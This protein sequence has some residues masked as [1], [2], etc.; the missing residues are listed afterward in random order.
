VPKKILKCEFLWRRLENT[1]L[2]PTR[3]LV[4]IFFQDLFSRWWRGLTFNCKWPPEAEELSAREVWKWA[5]EKGVDHPRCSFGFH[6]PWKGGTVSIL[7]Q[8]W[9]VAHANTLNGEGV[10]LQVKRLM[11]D[12]LSI[13]ERYLYSQC[14]KC[15]FTTQERHW[16]ASPR[17]SWYAQD[18]DPSPNQSRKYFENAHQFNQT[19]VDGCWWMWT[20]WQG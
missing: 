12:P 6:Y 4:V 18:Y 3:L 1:G 2:S 13:L 16:S 14:A 20:K 10:W 15:L 7:W 17:H 9:I 11:D 5:F 8:Q 19:H